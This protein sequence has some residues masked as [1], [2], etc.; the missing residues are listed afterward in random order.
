MVERANVL[1]MFNEMLK[2]GTRYTVRGAQDIEFKILKNLKRL[3][4]LLNND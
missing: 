3:K 4:H 1:Q 2:L